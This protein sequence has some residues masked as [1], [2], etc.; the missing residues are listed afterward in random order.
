MSKTLYLLVGAAVGAAAGLAYDYL[1]A[2]ARTT[3]F[4]GSYQSRLDWAL[5]EGEKAADARELE[6][7]QEFEAA[8]QP[9]PALPTPP[10]QPV[11]PPPGVTPVP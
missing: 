3:R 4:D 1:F 6:L 5:A 11:P 8:K 7:R 9:K 10:D 2:P